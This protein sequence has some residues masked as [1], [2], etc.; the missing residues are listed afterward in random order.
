MKILSTIILL[1]GIYDILCATSI[2]Q[3]INIPVI[4]DLHLS[5]LH[6]HEINDPLMRR[7]MAYWIFTYGILRVHGGY[8]NN[9][10]LSANSYYIEAIIIANECFIERT[11]VL[12]NSI[13]VIGSSI[14]LGV[15]CGY[16]QYIQIRGNQYF[17][18]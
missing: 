4:K 7:F 15:L 17:D 3:I 18:F 13:F 6:P 14:F 12:N 10:E 8:N 2:L 9:Y 1:N 16:S 11:M 5:M